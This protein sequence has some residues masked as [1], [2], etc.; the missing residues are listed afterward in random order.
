MDRVTLEI[1][2]QRYHII[3]PPEVRKALEARTPRKCRERM[4]DGTLVLRDGCWYFTVLT[5]SH[6]KGYD[7][8][9]VENGKEKLERAER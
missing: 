1:V 2:G 5:E 9:V 7:V 6:E 4:R 8:L 3:A